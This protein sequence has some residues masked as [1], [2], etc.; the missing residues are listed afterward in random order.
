MM[1]STQNNQQAVGTSDHHDRPYNHDNND[2]RDNQSYLD[3]QSQFESNV[4]S[5][6]R[7]LPFAI[8]AAEGVWLTDVNGKRYID[9][10]AGAGT[11]ALGHNHPVI[12][13]SITDT[14]ASNLPL[15][16]LDI[17][18]PLKD[19]FSQRLYELLSTDSDTYCLQ[20]CGPT[21][22]DA[23]EAALK[24]AK[25]ATGRSGII[26]FSGGYHGMTHGA[27]AVTGNL[28]PKAGV[29]GLMGNVQFLPYPNE[30]RC[31]FGLDGAQSVTAHMRYFE[32]FLRDV[33]SGFN[34]PAAVILEVIQG[35]GGVNPAPIEWLRHVRAVTRE[36]GILLIIDEVQTG[37]CR[38]G[39]WFAY[40]HAGI[41][42]DF[43]VMSKAVGGG[44]PMAVLGIK[45][46]LD[47]WQPG[48]H[49]G[50]FRGNQ[51]AMATGLATLDYLAEHDMAQQVAKLGEWFKAELTALATQYPMLGHVRGYGLMIGV[52]IVDPARP[53]VES[54]GFMA[55]P[56]RCAAIQQACFASGLVLEKGGRA[57]TVLRFLPPLI[58]TQEELEMVLDKFAAALKS[59]S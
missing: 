54:G 45:K 34:T 40:Q 8:A 39:R 28:A 25:K 5:Y 1:K 31:A 24:L 22:A 30:Y 23:V 14:L 48:E 32:S 7:K 6:P 59:V 56:N 58:I 41:D 55:D 52:E 21:G 12:T 20:F 51:L 29:E 27:L 42:P 36:L 18:T 38:T 16:T 33:E 11:L 4:R 57:G 15:H 3:R 26:S 17:T 44:L 47:V 19:A 9:C 53:E 43:V 50:T 2:R 10:L 49:S 46:A 35:E 37:F 13:K